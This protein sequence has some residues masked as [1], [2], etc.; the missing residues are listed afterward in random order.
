MT[1][2]LISPGKFVVGQGEVKR[3]ENYIKSLG[4][5]PLVLITDSGKNRLEKE[6]SEA[7][8]SLEVSYEYFNRECTKAEVER[9]AES[10]KTNEADVIVGIGG[11]KLIDASKAAAY[12]TNI[13]VIVV[14]TIA[15]TDAPC[16][17]LSVLYTEEGLFDEYLFLPENPNAVIMDT[18]I[19]AKSPIHLTISGVGDALATYFEARNTKESNSDTLVGGKQTV[20]AMALA[21]L[22]YK[23]LREEAYK[24]IKALEVGAITDSVDSLIEATTL[25]S[26]L[27]FESGGLGGAH[28]IHNGLTV[29]KETKDQSHGFLVAFGTVVSLFIEN[30]SMDEID[31]VLDFCIELGLPIC[32]ADIGLENA[33]K[34][35]LMKVAEAASVEG[36]SIHAMPVDIDAQVVYNAIIAA[37]S[38]TRSYI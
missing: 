8:T 26:G 18:E 7:F 15:S 30:A 3:L 6:L 38:Y 32:L 27:G 20:T 9:I 5:K 13:P 23:T 33:S 1:K 29:L 19:I 24:A 35:D 21:E 2:I 14:P 16:S 34:E 31:E 28:A 36:E 17:A 4:K 12:Y 22:C 37:D 11:G 10:I 25:L